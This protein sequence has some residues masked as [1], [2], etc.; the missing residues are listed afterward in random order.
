M[1]ELTYAEKVLKRSRERR[2]EARRLQEDRIAR[3]KARKN[4]EMWSCLG[5]TALIFLGLPFLIFLL[6]GATA[7]GYVSLIWM[8]CFQFPVLPILWVAAMAVMAYAFR[9]KNR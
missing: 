7:I 9:R 1:G 2:A 6:P 8:L 4:K 5:A 3:K